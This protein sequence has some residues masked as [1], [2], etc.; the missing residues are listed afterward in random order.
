MDTSSKIEKTDSRGRVRWSKQRRQ[1]LLVEFDKSG[2]SGPK[3]AALVGVNYQTLTGWLARRKRQQQLTAPLSPA[4]KA[5]SGVQN[6]FWVEAVVNKGF[7]EPKASGLVIRF[8]SGAVMELASLDQA[9]T[10][11]ALLRAWE[12][13][14][15]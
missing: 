2:L 14:P 7:Q 1:E 12:K 8:P 5:L 3:F 11:A 4:T 9:T 15:C 6:S 10:A 13:Q